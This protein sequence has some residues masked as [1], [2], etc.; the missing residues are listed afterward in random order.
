[1]PNWCNNSI[2]FY[3]EDDG[4]DMLAAF[5]ADVQKYQNYRDPETGKPS[6]W[7]GHWLNSSRVD[8][9]ILYCR[10]FFID[11]EIMNRH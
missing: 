6:D 1:M 4:S 7:V 11:C 8:T 10:G 3:Q 9:N 2:A 5:F